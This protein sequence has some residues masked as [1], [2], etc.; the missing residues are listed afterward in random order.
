MRTRV[1]NQCSKKKRCISD[2]GSRVQSCAGVE[3]TVIAPENEAVQ[4]IE[5]EEIEEIPRE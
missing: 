2:H 4:S 1:E 5:T 3:H